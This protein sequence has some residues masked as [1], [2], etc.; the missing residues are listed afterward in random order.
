[1]G[2]YDGW[3]IE[4]FDATSNTDLTSYAQGFQT[5]VKFNIG[6]FSKYAASITLDNDDGAFT[7]A[8]GG[9]T[10]TF[11]NTDWLANAI[12]IRPNSSSNDVFEGVIADAQFRDN[13]VNSTVT[14]TCKDWLTV[15]SSNRF[16]ISENTTEERNVDLMGKILAGSPTYTGYGTG[17]VLPALGEPTWTRLPFIRVL[18]NQDYSF[19]PEGVNAPDKLA[20]PAAT[21]VTSL[22]YINRTIFGGYPCIAA[23]NSILPFAF[24]NSIQYNIAYIGRSLTKDPFWFDQFAFSESPSG[25]TLAF[26]DLTFGFEFDDITTQTNID[27]GMTS[28][29]TATVTDTDAQNKYG[30]RARYY[31]KTGNTVQNDTGNSAG[32][33]GAASFWVERQSEARYIPRTL[34]TSVELIEKTNGA[35]GETE[36][37]SL[38]PS[39]FAPCN[40]TYTP[41][42]GSQ[43]TAK[44]VIS[45][46]T[47]NAT[48]GRTT[49]TLDL[50]PAQDY[51]SF[52][53][54][55][56]TLGVLNTNRLG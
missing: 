55:S 10:G 8:S 16:D 48:P 50:L 43:I 52:V 28:G 56:S 45:G 49:I 19:Y 27:S 36:L 47:V 29:P 1:M 13:G 14:L 42:G 32:A 35:T 39:I 17:A 3:T 44:C 7:P 6:R 5:R 25:T 23:P 34:T 12:R 33:S 24:A 15:A 22:D 11:A 30:T 26:S 54:N 18:S 37:H 40:I 46:M 51:Q 31:A 53:L 20:R 21:N 4:L 38:F 9:G 2:I 41:T